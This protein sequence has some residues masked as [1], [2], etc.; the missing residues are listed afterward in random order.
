MGLF[1]FA[2]AYVKSIYYGRGRRKPN[3]HRHQAEAL[4][5]HRQGCAR[6][7]LRQNLRCLLEEERQG[8]PPWPARCTSVLEPELAVSARSTETA[9][10]AVPSAPS[11]PSPP[12]VS[13]DASH[14]TDRVSST[15]LP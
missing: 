4:R 12:V 7:G 2:L 11:P 9:S 6:P 13:S 10:V 14:L 1:L 3:F 8:P 5:H 15:A